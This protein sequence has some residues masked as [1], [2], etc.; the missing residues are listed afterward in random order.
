MSADALARLQRASEVQAVEGG[1]S[2]AAEGV[3]VMALPALHGGSGYSDGLALSSS[4]RSLLASVCRR[5]A[6]TG[7]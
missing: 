4:Q 6:T 7:F 2:G 5:G 3:E 1:C